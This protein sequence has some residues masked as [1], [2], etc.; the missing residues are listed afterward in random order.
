MGV[1]EGN[2]RFYNDGSGKIFKSTNGGPKK[3][4]DP[5]DYKYVPK[6]AGGTRD[7]SPIPK[8]AKGNNTYRMTDQVNPWVNAPLDMAFGAVAGDVTNK[9]GAAVKVPGNEL[10]GLKL[11]DLYG[12][13][14][15]MNSIKGIFDKATKEQYKVLDKQYAN[16][17]KKFYD[18]MF[19]AQQT[20]LDT[21]RKSNA[22]AVATGASR[23]MQAANE[24]SAVLGMQQG[25][26][27]EAT[28]LAQDRNLL[29]DKQQAAMAQNAVT[30]LTQS[31]QSRQAIGGLDASKYAA[32]TQFDVG[33][34]D[35]YARIDA[36]SKGL[37]GAE[38]Q[39]AATKYMADQNLKG[40]QIA[41]SAS[42]SRSFSSGGPG[43]TAPP[44]GNVNDPTWKY[45]Q[46]ALDS[47]VQS[48]NKSAFISLM[49]SAGV[50]E[51]LA[52]QQWDNMFKMKAVG[53]QAPATSVDPIRGALGGKSSLTPYKFY[54][55]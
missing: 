50:D 49:T 31:N 21:I 20:A 28:Q 7:D 40:S 52:V 45:Q 2:N 55:E 5:K 46:L 36:A 33:Q 51:K 1:A 53:G 44:N 37:L 30:A 47:A 12:I 6:S 34:M 22:S 3:L 35:Y 23:G 18:N 43:Y 16:T 26:T 41:A 25:S 4:V 38:A 14:Y 39:A 11:G 17:E 32:D 29:N 48:G 24:L 42:A 9:A 27:V 8:G 54:T 19:G 15:D 10:M 13:N